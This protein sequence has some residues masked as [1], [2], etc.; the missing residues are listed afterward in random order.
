MT[1]HGLAERA[2]ERSPLVGRGVRHIL[3]ND[4]RTANEISNRMTLPRSSL[5]RRS[6]TTATKARSDAVFGG[7]EYSKSSGQCALSRLPLSLWFVS[8]T[9][10]NQL[11]ETNQT[12]QSSQLLPAFHVQPFTFHDFL[13]WLRPFVVIVR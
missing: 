6:S 12:N 11:R 3:E 5:L 7:G 9:W 8:Y 2:G 10:L 1:V 13:D 4:E